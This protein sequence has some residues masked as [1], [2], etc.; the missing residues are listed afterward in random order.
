MSWRPI[1]EW[2]ADPIAFEF[3]VLT[4]RW[5]GIIFG[6][7]FVASF[8]LV[9]WMY[10]REGRPVED[11][12][13][14]LVTTIIGTIVGARLMHCLA[15]EPARY[16]ANPLEILM[17][18]HGGL[19]SHGGMLGI[20][21]AIWLHARRRADQPFLWLLDR[22]AVASALAGAFVRCGNFINS[23]IIGTPTGGDWGVIF[24]RVDAQR[25]PRH[26]AQLYEAVA[27]FA[28]FGL[29]VALY[30][31]WGAK[32]P[33]GALVGLFLVLAFT[34]RIG[35]EF[36]KLR[37]ESFGDDLPFTMGQALS[38]IPVL[39]GAWLLARSRNAAATL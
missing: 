4:V 37:Q 26:P 30:K 13:S 22:V 12:E 32:T 21:A 9:R 11:V 16:L 6:S 18:W 28:I 25:L 10:R 5:Y 23:E 2:S 19:A 29:L 36:V 7:G 35:I 8:F 20:I 24:L 1:I 38:V 33:P 3:W 17:V 15:Y 34:V 14:L 39:A 27:Y 31:R